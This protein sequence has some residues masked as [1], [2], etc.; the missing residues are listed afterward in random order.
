MCDFLIFFFK[1]ETELVVAWLRWSLHPLLVYMVYRPHD[2]YESDSS[3]CGANDGYNKFT[4]FDNFRKDN[5][6]KTC[7]IFFLYTKLK[8]NY[9]RLW[10]LSLH[11]DKINKDFEN[12][13]RTYR[14]FKNNKSLE[15]YLSTKNDE[16]RILLSKLRISNHNL[17]IERGRQRASGK[18]K[19]L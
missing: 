6:P 18:R 19:N 4:Q 3:P 13:L 2:L 14:L 16:Q 17:E 15:S 1:T 7:F 11:D 8:S 5:S 12:K 9:N 10:F